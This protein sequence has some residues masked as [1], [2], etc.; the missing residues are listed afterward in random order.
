[1]ILSFHKMHGL[2]NDFVLVEDVTLTEAQIQFLGDRHR[3]IGFDQLIVLSP[4]SHP[5]ALSKISFF[6]QDGSSVTACG[7]GTR[8]GGW[9]LA[10]KH[11]QTQ[12]LLESPRGDL[13]KIEVTGTN[14]RTSL[15][16]YEAKPFPMT[17][18]GV[19]LTPVFVDIGNPHLVFFD[20]PQGMDPLQIAIESQAHFQGGINVGFATSTSRNS[21]DLQVWERGV[22][23]TQ[24]CGT[25]AG[26]AAIA[27]S[28]LGILED[29]VTV[30]Q[31]GGESLI[32][33]VGES[34]LYLTGPT[35]YVFEGTVQI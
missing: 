8:C 9:Y 27:G 14:V 26:A 11:S 7:N 13:M 16:V 4:S 3:G 20:C 29:K 12:F 6:N 2:G 23:F 17:L 5:E 30:H 1:M 35:T 33:W 10:Q 34:T 19:S 21:L 24:A 28:T 32:E 31:Q 25:G 15:K 22:G 18:G